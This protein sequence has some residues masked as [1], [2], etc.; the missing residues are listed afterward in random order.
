M[1]NPLYDKDFK[2]GYERYQANDAQK[3]SEEER[4]K[5]IEAELADT[6][7]VSMARAAEEAKKAPKSRYVDPKTS[8]QSDFQTA[9]DSIKKSLGL[10]SD[11]ELT[12]E[13]KQAAARKANQ[14][15]RERLREMRKQGAPKKPESSDLW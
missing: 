2:K 15:K 12:E 11:A 7:E 10:E 1:P 6:Y 3:K 4:K 13:Q 9:V 5:Q 14:S 8:E